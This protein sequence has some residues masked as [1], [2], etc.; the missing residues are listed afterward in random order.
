MS[1][2]AAAMRLPSVASVSHAPATTDTEARIRWP[3]NARCPLSSAPSARCIA[4]VGGLAWPERPW[5]FSLFT[6][7]FRLEQRSSHGTVVATASERG[8]GVLREFA[9]PYAPVARELLAIS[10]GTG[11]VQTHETRFALWRPA[12]LAATFR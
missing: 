4:T 5:P 12:E 9:R 10:R 2:S 11:S 6:R 8:P 3:S 1:R 7:L